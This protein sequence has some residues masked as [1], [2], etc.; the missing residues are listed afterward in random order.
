MANNRRRTAIHDYGSDAEELERLEAAM[1]VAPRG[2]VVVSG[3]A[4][5]LLI[6]CWLLIYIFVF[7]PRGTVG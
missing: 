1:D 7:L 5:G 6:L 3:V 2:A 4:V